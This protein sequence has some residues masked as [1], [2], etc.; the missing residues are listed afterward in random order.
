MAIIKC[1]ECGNDI[2]DKALKCP[3]CGVAT[4]L[5]V[6]SVLNDITNAE[7]KENSSVKNF[8]NNLIL[9]PDCEIEI[10]KNADRCPHCGCSFRKEHISIWE[11]I[12]IIFFIDVILT[13]L[14]LI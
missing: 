7:K 13:T 14:F 11:I 6:D 5:K 9:C 10:S 4:K 1:L 12:G 8:N 3:K 2:S